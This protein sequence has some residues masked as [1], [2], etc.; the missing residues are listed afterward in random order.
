MFLACEDLLEGRD[1]LERSLSLGR[2][3]S[4]LQTGVPLFLQM[5]IGRLYGTGITMGLGLCL[6]VHLL[7]SLLHDDSLSST[8]LKALFLSKVV[9]N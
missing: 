1:G 3:G 5:L 7:Q 2:E 9:I 8:T 6:G 4:H